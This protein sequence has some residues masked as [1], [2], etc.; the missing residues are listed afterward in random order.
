MKALL[1]NKPLVAMLVILILHLVGILFIA[2]AYRALILPLSAINLGISGLLAIYF[3][4]DIRHKNYWIWLG[5]AFSTGMLTEGIG[6]HTGILFGHYQY[7]ENLGPKLFGVPLI[8]GLNWTYL[9][10]GSASLACRLA[11][12]TWIQALIGALLM[13]LL[14]YFM[15]PI[16]IELDFWNWFG[17]AIPLKNYLSWFGISFLLILVYLKMIPNKVNNVA[18][19]LYCVQ[20]AFFAVLNLVG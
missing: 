18:I 4:R 12:N 10:I 5:I 15:E 11:K 19:L 6:V 13:T 1:A 9:C 7:L 17:E 16:A 3:H 8:I 20:L 14:D 2:S